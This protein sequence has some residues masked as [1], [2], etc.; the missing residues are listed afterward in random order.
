[1][2]PCDSEFEVKDMRVI[3]K[4]EKHVGKTVFERTDRDDKIG[5][6]VEDKKFI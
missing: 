1:M 3:D 2:E 4:K 5:L 6:S